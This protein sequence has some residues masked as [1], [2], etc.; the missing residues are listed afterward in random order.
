MDV[1]RRFAGRAALAAH[2]EIDVAAPD[3]GSMVVPDVLV[4]VD[5]QRGVLVLAEW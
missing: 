4:G 2:D 5:M 3:A 1:L